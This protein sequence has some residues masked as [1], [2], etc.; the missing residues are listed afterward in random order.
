VRHRVPAFI[1]ALLL[2]LWACGIAHAS[3]ARNYLDEYLRDKIVP[4]SDEYFQKHDCQWKGGHVFKQG[5]RFL[6]VYDAFAINGIEVPSDSI[7]LPDPLVYQILTEGRFDKTL[8]PKVVERATAV[9]VRLREGDCFQIDVHI[10][11]LVRRISS[12]DTPAGTMTVPGLPEKCRTIALPVKLGMTRAEM[13]K[14]FERDGGGYG[15]FIQERYILRNSA[16]GPKGEI[17]KV[18]LAFKPAGKPDPVLHIPLESPQDTVIRISLAYLGTPI[19]Y[20]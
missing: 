2:S 3:D 18:D 1:A 6:D 13:G 12:I 7:T 5:S 4:T 20:F 8:R 15:L 11:P 16:C 17:L 10:D 9:R 14:S 19:Y